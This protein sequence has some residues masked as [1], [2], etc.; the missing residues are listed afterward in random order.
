MLQTLCSADLVLSDFVLID[1]KSK[2]IE[3]RHKKNRRNVTFPYNLI[4]TP[5]MGC[6]MAF[7]KNVLIETLPFPKLIPMHDMWIGIIASLFFKVKYIDDK[8]LLRRLHGHNTSFE[9]GKST[10][11]LYQKIKIRLTLIRVLIMFI[12]KNNETN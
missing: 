1:E 11:S 2:I 6:C 5:F 4:N 8:L 10:N 7:R 9:D 12:L 3:G